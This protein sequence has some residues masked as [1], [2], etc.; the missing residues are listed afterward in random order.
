VAASLRVDVYAEIARLL[1]AQR[2]Y[3]VV[4]DATYATKLHGIFGHV[5]GASNFSRSSTARRPPPDP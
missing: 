5:P 1:P 4:S 3:F 2:V